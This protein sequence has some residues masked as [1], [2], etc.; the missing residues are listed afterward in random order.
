MI[1]MNIVVKE[2]KGWATQVKDVMSVRQEEIALRRF[3][4]FVSSDARKSIRKAPSIWK[5]SKPGRPPKSHTGLLK[6]HIIFDY[7]LQ[8]SSV[9]VGPMKLPVKG[10]TEDI[11]LILEEGGPVVKSKTS[12]IIQTFGTDFDWKDM[13]SKK[14]IKPRPYMTPAYL[15]NLPKLPAI[16]SYAVKRTTKT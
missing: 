14:N 3:G 9:I 2:F 16:W 6:D 12:R 7:S 4:A 10:R 15:K 1:G 5:T 11:P 8:E 13:P